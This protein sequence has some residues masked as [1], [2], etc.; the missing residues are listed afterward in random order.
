MIDKKIMHIDKKEQENK[1]IDNV[2]YMADS[3]S[4]CIDKVSDIDKEISYDS[5]FEKF[6]STYQLSNK[7]HN[8]FALLLRKGVCPYEYMDIWK[9]FNEPVPSVEDYYYSE[10]NKEG[11]T[12][13]DLKHAKKVCDTFKIKNLGEYHYYMFNLIQHYLLMYLKTLGINV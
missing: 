6:Y 8:K 3:L 4:K 1:F 5:L 2:R 11:I 10:L 7:D 13:E 12:K 9:R